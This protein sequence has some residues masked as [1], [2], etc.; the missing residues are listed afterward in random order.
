MA[1]LHTISHP[2][3]VHDVHFVRGSTSPSG[4]STEHEL[5]LVAAEDKKLSV[6][7]V[8]QTV[9]VAKGTLPVLASELV[10][11]SNRVK[12]VDT[13]KIALPVTEGGMSRSSTTIISTISS[14]GKILVYDLESVLQSLL[15]LRTDE[16]GKKDVPAIKPVV[17]YD[18]NGSRLTCLTLAEGETEVVSAGSG[19]RKHKESED[20]DE[21]EEAARNSDVDDGWGLQE[22]VEGE[23]EDEVEEEGEDEEEDE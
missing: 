21:D 2:S 14:D 19:K 10:G 18:S 1:L 5:L 20:E 12:A 23:D 22:E 11:H 3:R 6:Y 15:T 17:E 8:P 16:D 4:P 9:D 13:L 7:D